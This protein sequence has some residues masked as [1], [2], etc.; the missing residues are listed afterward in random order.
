MPPSP[1][2]GTR[3]AWEVDPHEWCRAV[4]I[5]IFGVY[6]LSHEVIPHMLEQGSGRIVNV[7]SGLSEIPVPNGSAYCTAKA[8]RLWSFSGPA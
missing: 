6:L 5:S 4:E 3:P 8:G 1:G 2:R 7:S